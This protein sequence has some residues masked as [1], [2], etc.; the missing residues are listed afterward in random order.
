VLAVCASLSLAG[1]AIAGSELRSLPTLGPE[2]AIV[3]ACPSEKGISYSRPEKLC[4]SIYGMEVEARAM[5]EKYT[6]LFMGPLLPLFPTPA[7]SDGSRPLRIEL[8][9]R[10]NERLAFAP[11]RASLRTEQGATLEVSRVQTN[12]RGATGVHLVEVDP[13]D[14][15]ARLPASFFEL[16]FAEHVPPEQEFVLSL[17]IIDPSGAALPMPTIRFSAGKIRFF[18][19]GP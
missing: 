4:F 5:N 1:C 19:L 17:E 15:E 6:A 16:T 10:A 12:V 18:V 2:A 11:W 3:H 13:R 14:R 8:D 7:E 9:F